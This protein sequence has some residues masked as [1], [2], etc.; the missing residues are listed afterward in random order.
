[1][2]RPTNR[3]AAALALALA[4]N[5]VAHLLAQTATDDV[6]KLLATVQSDAAHAEKL[7]GCHRLAQIGDPRA[8]AVLAPLLADEKLAHPARLA[9]EQIA[10]PAADEALRAAVPRLKGRLLAGAVNSL[11]VRRDAQAVGVLAPL[12]TDADAEV[13]DAAAV[14]LG[15]IATPAAAAALRNALTTADDARR[16]AVGD[17]C[18]RCGEVLRTQKQADAAYA[19]FDAVRAAKLSDRV[20]AGAVRGAVLCRPAGDAALFAETLKSPSP[21]MFAMALAVG[22]ELPDAAIGRAIIEH[23]PALPN[24][25]RAAALAVLGDRGDPAARPAAV[26]AARESDPLLRAAGLAALGRIGD[27]AAVSLLLEASVQS[28]ATIA[29]AARDSLA[30][31][32][33]EGVDAALAAQLDAAQGAAQRAAVEAVGR[34]RIAAAVPALLKLADAPDGELRRAALAALG[35]VISMQQLPSLVERLLK[36][37][38]AEEQAAALAAVRTACTRMADKEASAQLLTAAIRRAPPDARQNLFEALAAVG[39]P[40]ALAALAEVALS[41]DAQMQ[42]LATRVLGDW[43]T[44][45]AAP[46]LRDVAQK[47]QDA[48]FRVRALRGYL[49]IARQMDLPDP[50]RW[51][52]CREALKIAERNE[53][54]ALALEILGRSK[55]AAT[56]DV[57]APY[58]QDAHLKE[59]AAASVVAIAERL[60]P[61][62]L[63]RAV[64]PL[65]QAL[66]SA[67]NEALQRRAKDALARA[68]AA[69]PAAP[70]R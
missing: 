70:K 38:P 35:N 62:Q 63:A 27:A 5:S 64:E 56:L 69:Q 50:Q 1:M 6:P 33:G 20:R 57:L 32:S 18:L 8:V 66:Q 48:K 15:H 46:T 47:A 3:I 28:D 67:G 9:L 52:M 12:L 37:A 41:D 17:A 51:N 16:E 49:R 60:P 24:D 36:P 4:T 53:E 11:G 21:P 65:K 14:A 34:R 29:A 61:E 7:A 2:S 43:A 22:R 42:D 26:A 31:L 45:D 44:P 68:A 59:T 58:L 25:R 54:R 39:G 30:R 10:D 23:L 19:M 40:T 13:A 55:Q